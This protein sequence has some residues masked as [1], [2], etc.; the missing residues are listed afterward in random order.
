[1]GVKPIQADASFP[2]LNVPIPHIQVKYKG[3]PR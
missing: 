3:S 1:M 2:L